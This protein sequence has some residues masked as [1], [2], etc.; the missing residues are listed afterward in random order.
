L[1]RS[2]ALLPSFGKTAMPML[3]VT[4]RLTVPPDAS[5]SNGARIA[6]LIFSAID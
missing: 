2:S 6:L 1:T 4:P 5:T 3:A